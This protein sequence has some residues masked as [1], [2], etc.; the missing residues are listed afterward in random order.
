MYTEASISHY[1]RGVVHY[2]ANAASSSLTHVRLYTVFAYEPFILLLISNAR[3][4][5]EKQWKWNVYRHTHTPFVFTFIIFV[6]NHHFAFRTRDRYGFNRRILSIYFSLVC[7]FDKNRSHCQRNVKVLF[8]IHIGLFCWIW[9]NPGISKVKW[10]A[11]HFPPNFKSIFISA[12]NAIDINY[13]NIYS[14]IYPK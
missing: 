5:T 2:C 7:A 8:G 9:V 4:D 14:T 11:F 1:S 10:I 12:I 3:D 13:K 6:M